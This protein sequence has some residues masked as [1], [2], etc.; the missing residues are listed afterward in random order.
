MDAHEEFL[1]QT[2][3]PL[4]KAAQDE[5]VLAAREMDLGVVAGREDQFDRLDLHDLEM[6]IDGQKQP[7]VLGERFVAGHTA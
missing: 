2:L 4:E 5:K 7:I 1:G 6:V 3:L